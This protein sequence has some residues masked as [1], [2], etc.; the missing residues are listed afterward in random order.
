[1]KKFRDF[2]VVP[3]SPHCSKAISG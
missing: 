3:K 1:M 2:C